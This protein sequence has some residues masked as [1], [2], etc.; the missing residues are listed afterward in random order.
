MARVG[1]RLM[2]LL[3]L[4]HNVFYRWTKIA[5]ASVLVVIGS[6]IVLLASRWPFTQRA[7][8][9]ALQER[10]SSTVDFKTFRGTY[11]TP[12]CVAEG[13]TF[14]LND[15]RSAP[16]LATVEKLTIQGGYIGLF[17]SPKRIGRVKV[18]GLRVLV[19]SPSERKTVGDDEV[20]RTG[21][22]TPS[23]LIVGEII[24]DGAVLQVASDTNPSEPLEF[25]IR[26]LRLDAVADDRPMSFHADLLN[27]EPTGEVRA[28][29]QFG[30]LKP[31]D[32]NHTALSGSYAFRRANLGT[33]A[34]I[35][36]TLSSDGTFHGVLEHIDVEGA[37]DVPD[38]QVKTSG[39]PVHLKAQ[40]HAVVNGTDGNVALRPVD[41]QFAETSVASQG[42]VARKPSGIGKTVSIDIT[43][44]KGRI[45]D[46]LRLLA[47]SNRPALT[48]SM[49]F[50]ARVG[51]PLEQRRFLD[52]IT[53]QGDFGIDTMRFTRA[54]TQENVNSLSDR[55]QGKKEDEPESVISN[56]KGHVELKNGIATFST[57]S[58]SVPGALARLHGTY[59]LVNEQIDL[60]GTLQLDTKL[61]KESKGIKLA[62]LKVAEPFLKKK[63]AGEVVPIKLTG[64]YTHPSY[65]VD[66]VQVH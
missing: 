12:G 39:H 4:E 43:E 8:I 19:P 41:A 32:F 47:E 57:L 33:F 26:Q 10:F 59:G 2:S 17:T 36:G 50:R 51:F 37:T 20:Q 60:H 55:A 58:F 11:L 48:G 25:D 65:G 1:C 5:G 52:Q 53:L 44:T 34:G 54:E 66:Y 31:G 38:F 29:G 62:L 63:G 6:L 49:N 7:V 15:D 14:H 46:W 16:P 21:H 27:P 13:V 18:E 3:K 40:F 56:L 42:E 24:A 9:A 30:P 35:V 22:T 45:E 61:S 28:D 64:S 23:T